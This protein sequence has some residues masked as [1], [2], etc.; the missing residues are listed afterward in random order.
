LK[1][2]V[3]KIQYSFNSHEKWLSLLFL[4]L[5]SIPILFQLG[6]FE[7]AGGDPD[8]FFRPLKAELVRSLAKMQ[9]PLWSDLFGFGMPLASQSEIGAFYLPHYLIYGL[10]GVSNGYRISMVL[11]QIIAGIFIWKLAS[12]WHSSRLG[13][14]IAIII[15]LFGGFSTIQASKEW[16]VLGMAWL[17]GAFL[18][19][20]WWT[21]LGL[22][23]WVLTRIV[24]IPSTL[25]SIPGMVFSI[26][27]AILIASPQLALSWKYANEVG[28]TERSFSTLA[29]YSYPLINFTELFF[30]LWTRTLKGGPEG[31]YWTLHQTTQF[32]A[33][34]F[35]GAAGIIFAV[36]GIRRK[37]DVSFGLLILTI[38]SAG[39]S[40]MPQWS[41]ESYAIILK[42][43]GMGLFRCPG[44][45]GLLLHFAL[46]LLAGIGAGEKLGRWN[47][48]F[49]FV[50]FCMSFYQV[51]QLLEM[52]FQIPGSAIR[53][54][55]DFYKTILSGSLLFIIGI[56]SALKVSSQQTKWQLLTLILVFTEM[57][58]FYQAGPTRWGLSLNP[59]LKSRI[60]YTLKYE[61]NV[62]L[63]GPLDNLPVAAGFRTTAAYF[64]MKMP[65]AN[66]M[67]KSIVES[68]VMLDRQGKHGELDTF[69]GKLGTTHQIQLSPENGAEI[70]V[71]DPLADIIAP[72]PGKRA[73]LYLRKIEPSTKEIATVSSQL[74]IVA[75]DEE[76]FRRW[77]NEKQPQ[78]N[79]FVTKTVFDQLYLEP[80]ENFDTQPEMKFEPNSNTIQLKSQS[81][82]LIF[83]RRTYDSGWHAISDTKLWPIIFPANGGLT[84]IYLRG[85]NQNPNSTTFK[86]IYWPE[87]LN[88]T[89]PCMGFGLIILL[90]LIRPVKTKIKPDENM[91]STQ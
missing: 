20:E 91:T 83:I 46:A 74:Q 90:A 56:W 13:R 51:M 66:E 47:L 22:F 43:P 26:A 23:V 17:P 52:Q 3:A 24:L 34:Q 28:A 61:N 31:A 86:L 44:R 58:Y 68:V 88:Y 39:L 6:G 82:V 9:L 79:I 45:Y 14:M 69:L 54:Q 55:F 76:A 36:L 29:Y 12:H 53:I 64:G 84:G 73:N 4:F 8:R 49:I 38:V 11:H 16:A 35:V 57:L 21:S 42:I 59:S 65:P 2:K 5:I 87:S 50:L 7:V 89:L 75:S 15:Y 25:R 27:I 1:W 32:E 78:N 41:P 77:L 72:Q 63:I 33:C 80:S 60:F 70:Y 48:I 62:S 30:P 10:F 40:T 19:T 37:K 71:D 67:A 18:G 85:S 81:S